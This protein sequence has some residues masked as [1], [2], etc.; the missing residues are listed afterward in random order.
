MHKNS[1]TQ[2]LAETDFKLFITLVFPCFSSEYKLR[3]L[4]SCPLTGETPVCIFKGLLLSLRETPV[5][6]PCSAEEQSCDKSVFQRCCAWLW[7]PA[8]EP[9]PAPVRG[10]SGTFSARLLPP[11]PRLQCLHTWFYQTGSGLQCSTRRCLSSA[12]SARPP[13]P[14]CKSHSDT[15]AGLE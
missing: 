5:R 7:P 9:A 14:G 15:S 6:T 12:C 3:N 2:Q 8:E 1:K 10:W 4:K 11:L 13:A